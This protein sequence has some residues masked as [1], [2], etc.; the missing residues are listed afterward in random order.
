MIRSMYS[1]PRGQT[2]YY[3][4]LI[5]RLRQGK[6]FAHN[7]MVCGVCRMDWWLHIHSWVRMISC[8]IW[9]K[10]TVD[11][12]FNNHNLMLIF[13]QLLYRPPFFP[14]PSFPWA[15][16]RLLDCGRTTVIYTHVC[17]YMYAYT[18]INTCHSPFIHNLL[19]HLECTRHV[20]Y[21]W[22]NIQND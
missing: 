19:L 16:W 14:P 21:L 22:I 13:I 7:T 6:V 15:V 17:M 18:Y 20:H 12:V 11:D 1:T 5:V 2:I 8:K 3:V 10:G 9:W 4:Q